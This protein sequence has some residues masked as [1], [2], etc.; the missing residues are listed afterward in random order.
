MTGVMS[1]ANEQAVE[2]F[3]EEKIG[4]LDIMKVVE[5]CCDAHRNDFVQAPSLEEIVEYDQW[6]RR[7]VADKS[8]AYAMA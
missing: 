8:S 5:Q 4:Y 7:W 6:A 1:A 3:L 2:L